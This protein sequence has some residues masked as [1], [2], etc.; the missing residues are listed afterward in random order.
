MVESQSDFSVLPE[1]G[2]GFLRLGALR[3]DHEHVLEGSSR[4]V[5]LIEGLVDTA[6]AQVRVNVGVVESDCVLVVLSGLLIPA[7][8]VV[9]RGEV[10]V[11]LR[12][13]VVDRESLV[14][15]PHGLLELVQHVE[16]V[17]EVVE[18]WG[19]VG[20]QLNGPF[21]GLNGLL[22]LRLDAESVA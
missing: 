21:V 6:E 22:V 9:G 10:E 17:A 14:V 7:Q 15:R 20:I 4:L 2:E 8:V 18:G 19:V 11:A 1:L 5:V 13:L 16:R 3:V 12:R